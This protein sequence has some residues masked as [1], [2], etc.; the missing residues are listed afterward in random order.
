MS[1]QVK[2]LIESEE[3]PEDVTESLLSEA[4][5]EEAE[6]E[7]EIGAAVQM[8]QDLIGDEGMDVALAAQSAAKDFE[9]P[10]QDVYTALQRDREMDRDSQNSS[11]YEYD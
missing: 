9:V 11:G 5:E 2:D 3:S 6:Q 7:D 4:G 10:F 8:A 1:D